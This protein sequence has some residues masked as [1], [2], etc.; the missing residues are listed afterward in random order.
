MFPYFFSQLGIIQYE[1][2]FLL[3]GDFHPS[4]FTNL[5]R[6]LLNND[7]DEVTKKKKKSADYPLLEEMECG[8]RLI[9]PGI[10]NRYKILKSGFIDK[11]EWMISKCIL[12]EIISA[13]DVYQSALYLEGLTQFFLG[14]ND[15]ELVKEFEQ[16]KI[17]LTVI[18][19]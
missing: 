15:V 2:P 16:C 1:N 4:I 13:T 10:M 11:V 17:Q 8:L 18:V 19:R 6:S 12:M 3:F 9:L 14:F 5:L 7:E